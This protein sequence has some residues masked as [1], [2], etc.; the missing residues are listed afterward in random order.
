LRWEYLL[1]R[2]DLP[3]F[4]EQRLTGWTGENKQTAKTLPEF[5][6]LAGEDGWEMVGHSVNQDIQANG[7]TRPYMHGSRN[8]PT[9]FGGRLR[10]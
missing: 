9:G 1:V 3:G 7:V 6:R 10:A 2:F 5:L 4:N 8:T